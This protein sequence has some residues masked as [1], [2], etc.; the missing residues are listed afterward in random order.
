MASTTGKTINAEFA[1]IRKIETTFEYE[2]FAFGIFGYW[3]RIYRGVIGES[4]ELD[5]SAD[6]LRSCDRMLLNG[7]EV[8]IPDIL[9]KK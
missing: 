8:K 6:S 3:R 5:V 4:I 1:K 9:F 2:R 7:V